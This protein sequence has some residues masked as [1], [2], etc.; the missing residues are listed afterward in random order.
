MEASGISNTLFAH[1]SFRSERHKVISSNIAN[2]NTPNYKTKDLVFESELQKAG[3]NSDLQ[4]TKTHVN[5][6]SFDNSTEDKMDMSKY[7]QMMSIVNEQ[8]QD[9]K[10]SQMLN[11][12]ISNI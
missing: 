11:T 12:Y 10:T 9:P 2:L 1:L 7:K 4:M 6:I 8:I 3:S 5:H